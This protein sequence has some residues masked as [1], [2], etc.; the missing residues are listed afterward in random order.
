MAMPLDILSDW[1][2][3]AITLPIITLA[4]FAAFE[5][6][7]L[8]TYWRVILRAGPLLPIIAAV[9][10]WGWTTTVSA[11]DGLRPAIIAAIVVATGWFVTFFFQEFRKEDARA[12][13]QEDL[14]LA[15]RAEIWIYLWTLRRGDT[16]AYGEELDRQIS[17]ALQKNEDFVPFL[18]Q[19]SVP[20]AFEGLRTQLHRAPSETVDTIVQFYAALSDA[21]RFVEEMQSDRFIRLPLQRRRKAYRDYMSMRLQLE[22]SADDAVA[23]INRF[24]RVGDGTGA[25][26]GSDK[27]R[28]SS[29]EDVSARKANLRNWINNQAAGPSAQSAHADFSG[30]RP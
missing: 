14:L 9:I 21:R 23:T 29:A 1:I 10:V 13:D 26:N 28:S 25:P 3:L 11:D 4:L 2:G 15:L 8:R 17:E 24:L 22:D 12:D 19:L 18:T 16:N 5:R 30:R 6:R 20:V 7:L 27:E